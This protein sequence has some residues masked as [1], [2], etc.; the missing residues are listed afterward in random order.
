MHNKHCHRVTAHLQ[1]IIII[2]III[3][4]IKYRWAIICVTLIAHFLR[5]SHRIEQ[6]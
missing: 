6:W 4:I 5:Y 2:I 1:F 3:I